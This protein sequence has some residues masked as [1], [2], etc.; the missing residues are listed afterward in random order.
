MRKGGVVPINPIPPH[1][2][3]VYKSEEFPPGERIAL[4]KLRNF[5]HNNVKNYIK[6]RDVPAIDGTNCLSPYLTIGVLSPRQCFNRLRTEHP[7]LL[8]NRDALL[9][10]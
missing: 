1:F 2:N 7:N 6:T 4:D 5:C 10:G 3:D 9:S 8:G